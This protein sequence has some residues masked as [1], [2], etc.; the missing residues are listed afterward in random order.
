MHDQKRD[1]QIAVGNVWALL[2]LVENEDMIN[3]LEKVEEKVSHLHVLVASRVCSGDKM[4]FVLHL[5]VITL[6][7]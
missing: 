6:Y 1:Q 5:I 7:F 3:R 4:S 2:D